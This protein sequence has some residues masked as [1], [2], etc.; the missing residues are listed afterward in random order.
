MFNQ[1]MNGCLP[2]IPDMGC[3]P[4]Q[5]HQPLEPTMQSLTEKAGF[6]KA[7]CFT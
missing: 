2:A 4:E 3:L 1:V 5:V 7:G 6:Y